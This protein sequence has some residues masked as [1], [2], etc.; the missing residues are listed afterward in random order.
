MAT[1]ELWPSTFHILFVRT[2]CNNCKA[3]YISLIHQFFMQTLHYCLELSL[4]IFMLCVYLAAATI[5]LYTVQWQLKHILFY[6]TLVFYWVNSPYF[7]TLVPLYLQLWDTPDHSELK[8]CEPESPIRVN[9]TLN[10]VF[11]CVPSQQ[12]GF[13]CLLRSLYFVP[14]CCRDNDKRTASINEFLLW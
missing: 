14:G 7:M 1:F 2:M 11:Q 9:F 6:S 3:L 8:A 10:C 12:N 5:S 13:L 4:A